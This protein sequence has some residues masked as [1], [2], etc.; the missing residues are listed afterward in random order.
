MLIESPF[1]GLPQTSDTRLRTVAVQCPA[2]KDPTQQLPSHYVLSARHYLQAPTS[3]FCTAF[4]RM[5]GW[6]HVGV[7]FSFKNLPLR[8]IVAPSFPPAL[9]CFWKPGLCTVLP[10]VEI[11]TPKTPQHHHS[12]QKQVF[13]AVFNNSAPF[14]YTNGGTH[15]QSSWVQMMKTG[16]KRL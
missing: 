2:Y 11:S 13:S 9:F 14:L 5:L 3:S 1:R 15:Q 8:S 4:F 12:D 10:V 16:F 6:K 7:F